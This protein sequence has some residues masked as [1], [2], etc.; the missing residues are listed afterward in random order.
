MPE[1]ISL[2]D[3]VAACNLAATN[4]L[5]VPAGFDGPFSGLFTHLFARG[6]QIILDFYSDDLSGDATIR[7]GFRGILVRYKPAQG[8]G[9]NTSAEVRAAILA[10]SQPMPFTNIAQGGRS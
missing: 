4:P 5:L 3:F 1:P 9:T 2:Q 10:R 8:R 6:G 7:F